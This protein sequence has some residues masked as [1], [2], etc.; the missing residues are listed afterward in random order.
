MLLKESFNIIY[1]T[2]ILEWLNAFKFELGEVNIKKRFNNRDTL[3]NSNDIISSCRIVKMHRR[4]LTPK[5]ISHF[6]HTRT[7]RNQK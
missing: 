2:P 7:I 4:S 5:N 1:Q 6:D 3:C